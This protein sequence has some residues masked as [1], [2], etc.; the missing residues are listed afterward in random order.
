M[1]VLRIVVSS[2]RKDAAANTSSP[3]TSETAIQPRITDA[4]GVPAT[5]GLILL[6]PRI[7]TRP[8]SS[9]PA[10]TTPT[11]IS[12]SVAESELTASVVAG[13][14]AAALEAAALIIVSLLVGLFGC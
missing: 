5:V 6:R 7:T 12:P 4:P 1:S 13:F 9:M 3:I 10:T 14:D 2:S 11:R 8:A